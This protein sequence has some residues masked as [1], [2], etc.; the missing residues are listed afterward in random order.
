[1]SFENIIYEV[2]EGIGFLTVNRPDKL[3]A[4][5]GRV[6]EEIVNALGE[7][8][9]DDTVKVLIVTGSGQ[10]A[11][12]AG[13]DI[14]EIQEIGLKGG[15]DFSRKGQDMNRHIE[16]LGKPSI[17]AVNGLALGGG[18]ELALACTFRILSDNAKLGLPELAL[19]AI[20]GYGG[21]QRMSRIIGKSR[22]LW[23]MLTG[24]MV[25]A[26]DALHMGL[27]NRVVK[28]EELMA[29]AV[30]T[31]K[32]IMQ[33]APLAVKMAMMAVQHGAETDLES[34]LF[35]ESVLANVVL[36]S[37]DKEEGI[38]AFMEKR[39]PLFTGN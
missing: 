27:A 4:L 15:L 5:N 24:E 25:G 28:P 17:A 19:G 8:R 23:M 13:A 10:K 31:A 11:F 7:I 38:A 18:C 14:P 1:M 37:K 30:E 32:K 36:G 20:P 3:N 16:E 33:K 12:V 29:A 6:I 35:L 21:T 9:R 39:K 2:K 22:A 34:G 26:E